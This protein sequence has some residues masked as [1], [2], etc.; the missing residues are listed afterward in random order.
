[1]TALVV[2]DLAFN[3]GASF[4]LYIP[5]LCLEPGSMTALLGPN[6]SGK[7]TL[8]R[9]LSGLRTPVRGVVELFG[10]DLR[11]LS[12]PGI[13][14]ELA[15]VHQSPVI[16]FAFT[17]AEIVMLGRIAYARPL[18]GE[19]RDDRQAVGHALDVTQLS[20]LAD[21]V[22]AELSGGEQQ[23]VLLA[24]AIAQE[25]RVLLLDEPTAHLDIAFQAHMLELVSELN[26][27]AGIT[28]L[29]AL[30]DLNL[31]ALYFPRLVLMRAGRIVADG[32]PSVVVDV[33]TIRAVFGAD[34][35]L[36]RHP[37]RGVPQVLV[38]PRL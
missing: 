37:T 8:V 29:A 10:R 7:T 2:A 21:H 3:Y 30:H 23:R 32:P 14:R 26:R 11:R 24:M 33:E 34:T 16:P 28:V 17:V 4:D 31:A 15:I 6:G 36:E 27:N 1:V 13:A 12:R 22:Y 35:V 5:S 20:G 9:L 38:Q 25:P 19:S 18:R